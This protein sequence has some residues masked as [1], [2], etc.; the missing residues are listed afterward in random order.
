MGRSGEDEWAMER[1]ETIIIENDI[2]MD[3]IMG[4]SRCDSGIDYRNG[5]LCVR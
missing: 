5:T 4:G 2:F 3:E 1:R